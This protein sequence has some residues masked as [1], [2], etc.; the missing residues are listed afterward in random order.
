MM[1]RYGRVNLGMVLSLLSSLLS[2]PFGKRYHVAL[3]V[4]FTLLTAVH[5]WQHRKQFGHYLHKERQ[6]MDLFSL[7]ESLLGPSVKVKMFM[8]KIQVLHYIPGRVRLYSQHL[9]NNPEVVRQV[10]QH[11]ESMPEIREFK[12]NPA[13]GSLLIQYS[14][15]DVARNPFLRDVEQLVVKQYGR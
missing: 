8:Q 7:P 5:T 10:R 15:E 9:I 3:G 12:L 6:N 13:T 1:L 14:P 2:L 11:L 4:C